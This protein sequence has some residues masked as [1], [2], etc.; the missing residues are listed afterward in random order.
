MTS[1]PGP[2]PGRRSRKKLLLLLTLAGAIVLAAFGVRESLYRTTDPSR[3]KPDP[4]PR[5][6]RD[7]PFIT[8]PDTVVQAMVD[9]ATIGKDDLV[10]DLGCG[11]GRIVIAAAERTGCRGVGI[12]IDPVRICEAQ[13]NAKKHGVDQLVEFV[14]QDVFKVDLREADVVVMYL[15]PW[16]ANELVPQFDVM[17][18]GARIVAH[19]FGMEEIEPEQTIEVPLPDSNE[20]RTLLLYVTPL[21]HKPPKP[22]TNPRR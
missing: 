8:S 19:D 10:Y 1:A 22:K 7:A 9:L 6:K 17:Q 2:P 14:E 3:F 20:K 11:D 21:K 16:M 5:K 15:L 4:L 13:E 18:P 12:D